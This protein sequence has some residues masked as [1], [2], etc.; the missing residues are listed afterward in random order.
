MVPASLK[1]YRFTSV[2]ALLA[3]SR[4]LESL[5]DGPLTRDQI[6]AKIYRSKTGTANYLRYLRGSREN[7]WPRRIYIKDWLPSGGHYLPSYALGDKRDKPEPPRMTE[8]QRSALKM[9]KLRADPVKHE[10]FKARRREL[11]DSKRPRDTSLSN[12]ILRHLGMCDGRSAR[13][14][15]QS[16]DADIRCVVT[17]LQRLRKAGKVEVTAKP[18][19]KRALHWSVV[20]SADLSESRPVTVK[21]WNRQVVAPQGWASALFMGA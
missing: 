13:Q 18:G 14:I 21:A 11:H 15:A 20:G 10:A 1:E 4:I 19:K 16:L 12:R 5:T 17:N 9:Q 2:R 7:G 3:I 6:S 8:K